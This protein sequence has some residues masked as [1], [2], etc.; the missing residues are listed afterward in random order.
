MHEDGR[1][2]REREPSRSILITNIP[3]NV[4]LYELEALF[5]SVPGT[6]AI[7]LMN[8]KYGGV[9]VEDDK[10]TD[11]EAAFLL[12]TGREAA[13]ALMKSEWKTGAYCRDMKMTLEFAEYGLECNMKTRVTPSRVWICAACGSDN[14]PKRD[15]CFSCGKLRCIGCELVDPS[16]PTKSLRITNIDGDVSEGDLEARIKSVAGVHS[17]RVL[18]DRNTR[19]PTGCAY[20]NCFSVD[21]AILIRESLHDSPHGP[22]GQLLQIEFC[23]E[24]VHATRDTKR[25]ASTSVAKPLEN[26]SAV[27]WEPAE[28]D[29]KDVMTNDAAATNDA[30]NSGFVYDAGSGYMKEVSSGLY[31]DVHSGY[32]YDPITQ[33]W[34][35]K[36]PITNGFVP[37]SSV[38]DEATATAHDERGTNKC[39]AHDE[40]DE[41]RETSKATNKAKGNGCGG[42]VIGAAA[43]IVHGQEKQKEDSKPKKAKGIIHK[44]TWAK[45]K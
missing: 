33:V 38:T 14:A 43:Q 17:I 29:E 27:D 34:G 45:K 12:M 41:A 15:A 39:I 7:A 26:E 10:D 23:P 9:V 4:K 20:C 13:N 28:F 2:S 30:E 25:S 35:T 24:R 44:G 19:R 8:S 11:V 16:V 6:M 3:K 37:Y 36:D 31:Y 32:Y 1:V 5:S 21:N 40:K 18:R 22:L 42:A